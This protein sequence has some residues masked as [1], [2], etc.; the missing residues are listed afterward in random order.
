MSSFVEMLEAVD[1]A[2]VLEVSARSHS[3]GRYWDEL[4]ISI[5]PHLAGGDDAPYRLL[6]D[7]EH[8]LPEH[9]RTMDDEWDRIESPEFADLVRQWAE[10][11]LANVKCDLR[12]V[13]DGHDTVEISRTMIVGEDWLRDLGDVEGKPLPASRF[14]YFWSA[15]DGASDAYFAEPGQ[16]GA[17]VV[18]TAD[19][20]PEAI[21]YRTTLLAR[22]DYMNAD[23]EGEIRLL[24]DAVVQVREIEVIKSTETL[25][26]Q[27][28]AAAPSL[29][30]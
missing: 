25:D 15:E 3:G 14:G 29:G 21:D 23:E 12:V 24:P 17:T 11:R 4:A 30:G 16:K 1:E 8:L 26:A 5:K 2:D 28:E 13:F 27:P 18:V 10:A 20:L 6:E 9:V 19:I 7:L 22:M